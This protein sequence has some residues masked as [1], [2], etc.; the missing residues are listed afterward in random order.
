MPARKTS[1]SRASV[2]ATARA[3]EVLDRLSARLVL[4]PDE[5][6]G[7]VEALRA[8]LAAELAPRGVVA[9]LILQNILQVQLELH[10]LARGGQMLIN[11]RA[12][13]HMELHLM[14]GAQGLSAA[15]A[16]ALARSW[17]LGS[18]KVQGKARR[19]IAALDVNEAEVLAE[20]HAALAE[21]LSLARRDEER[22]EGR[23]RKLL[24]DYERANGL[25]AGEIEDAE[26]I[27]DA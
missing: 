2:P 27:D 11:A 5:D 21:V 10:R 22:L 3:A 16:R 20:T 26:V 7:E 13:D 4:A 24:E 9:D 19:E 14:R 12:A 23:R 15:E 6:A 18:G 1:T 17:A 25:A 8:A